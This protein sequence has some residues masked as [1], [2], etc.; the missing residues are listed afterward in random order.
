M[1]SRCRLSVR[2]KPL[3][4]IGL[5]MLENTA[6]LEPRPNSPVEPQ[7]ASPE[8]TISWREPCAV[9][10]AIFLVDATVYHGAGFA[11]IALLLFVLPLL[12][13]AGITVPR[14]NRL[15]LLF[16]AGAAAV[17]AKLLWCGNGWAAFL[18]FVVVFLFAAALNGVPFR[19]FNLIYYLLRLIA[20][21]AYGFAD[22]FRSSK[23][24]RRISLRSP[25]AVLIPLLAVVVF[26][27]IFV[28]ANSDLQE[29]LK[30]GWTAF[31][32]WLGQFSDWLPAGPQVAIWI[33]AGWITIGLLR[34]LPE[35]FRLAARFVWPEI[36]SNQ[37]PPALPGEEVFVAQKVV[38]EDAKVDSPHYFIF[39][40]TLLA[41]N[42]LFAVYLVFEF[43]KN[44]TRDFPPGFDYSRHMHLGAAYLT[45]ALGLSTLIL[46]AIFQGDMLRDPRIGRLKRLAGIWSALNFL[47]AFSVYNR[48]YIY[49]DLN[50]LSRLRI[51]GLLG[52]TAVV[53]GLV[54]VVRMFLLSKKIDWLLQRYA[55]SV[56]A[57]VFL[58]LVFPFD[59]LIAHHNVARVMRGDL[60]PSI[61]L[62]RH[63]ESA[64]D[65]LASLPLLDSDDPIIREG[66]WALFAE[67]FPT[68]CAPPPPDK[69]GWTAFQWSEKRLRKALESRRGELDVFL[70]DYSKREKAIDS[71]R[72]YTDRWI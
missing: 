52:T 35:T 3:K 54:M 36:V 12:F 33:A 25:A 30:N 9:L 67:K 46:C 63:P 27:G 72:K 50:G 65:Y 61:F 62:L 1:P 26:A 66:A 7:P 39:R 20:S 21:G 43:Y 2:A 38:E 17:A 42:V 10:L 15:I 55:V 49:I 51:I 6:P 57:V 40:N 71:F 37:S 29:I 28:C 34:P 14:T 11:G 18:G 58:G 23:R 60:A 13:W 56:F 59:M 68:L 5:M 16:A 69:Y 48:L 41:L 31:V 53:L 32:D 4:P 8:K 70:L 45:F 44:W 24:L 64:E 19:Y 47:L 22:Y